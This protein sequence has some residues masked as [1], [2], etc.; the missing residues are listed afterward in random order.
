MKRRRCETKDCPGVA[1]HGRYC[2]ACAVSTPAPLWR[3]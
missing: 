1:T 2:Y 3:N